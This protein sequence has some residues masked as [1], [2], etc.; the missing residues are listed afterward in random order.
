M[1]DRERAAVVRVVL[2]DDHP[3]L[4]QG[5]AA[6]LDAD[7]GMEVVGATGE[8]AAAIRLVEELRPDVLLLDVRL[9]DL[10]GVEVARRVRAAHPAVAVLV[11]T[12]YEDASYVRALLALGV[13][14]YLGKSASGEEIVAAVRAVA[15]GRTVL[16][17]AA[18]RGALGEQAP[19]LTDRE[20]EVLRLLATGRR[21]AEIAEALTVSLRTV[22]FHV[23]NV[24][25]K[26][27]ARSRTDAIRKARRQGLVGAE[28]DGDV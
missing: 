13:G 14:G 19:T 21:N 28:N 8:G 18:A 23:G 2:V 7:A 26:L 1:A 24:L 12:G 17:S 10:S 22:E 4:R 5:T 27:G 11:L 25:S 3:A 15:A 9:P 20:A 16:V 6:I